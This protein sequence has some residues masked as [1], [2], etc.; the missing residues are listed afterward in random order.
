MI[1]KQRWFTWCLVIMWM[2]IIFYLSHQPA[3]TSSELSGGIT[4]WV[5][6]SV[7]TALP[8]PIEAEAF[9]SF[10]RKFA[11]FS[12]Y[13]VLGILLMAALR[14]NQMF[15]RICTAL[16][17]A[18]LYAASDEFHQTFIPGRSGEVRDVLI[19]TAGSMTGILVYLCIHLIYTKK[20][21]AHLSES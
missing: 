9:H 12:A 17:I 5:I 1:I 15:H 21:A 11:H 18:I 6:P 7:Q 19:D 20:K 14:L 8:F 2:F 3:S 16:F 13:F 4:K 10:I